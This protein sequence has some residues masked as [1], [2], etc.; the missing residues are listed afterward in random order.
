MNSSN[1]VEIL[2]RLDKSEIR[3]FNRWLQSPFYNK[4]EDVLSLFLYLIKANHLSD[5]RY[6]QKTRV[7]SK[8]FPKEQYDD[9]KLRQ[10]VHFLNKQV[11]AFLSHLQLEQ[12]PHTKDLAFLK[13]LRK[14]KLK[15]AFQKKMN[16]LQKTQLSN[17]ALDSKGLRS[18]FILNDENYSFFLEANQA[19]EDHLR[20]TVDL[21]DVQFVAEKLK[22]ACLELSHNK[23]FKTNYQS[24]FLDVVLEAVQN[25]PTLLEYPAIKVYYY[26]YLMQTSPDKAAS[27]YSQLKEAMD[28]F[29]FST[30]EKKDIYLMVLNYCVSRMNQ[31]DQFFLRE[32]FGLF[33]R[34]ITTG[35][36]IQNGKLSTIAYLNTVSIGLRLK[37]FDEIA[38][39]IKDFT[40]FLPEADRT[41]TQQYSLAK[42][43]FEQ[44]QYG[45]VLDLLATFDT[46]HI[47]INLNAKS[48]ML[49]VFYELDELDALESYLE[50]FRAY[51]NRKE[52]ISY[53]RPIYSNLVKFT[54]KLVRVNAYDSTQLEKLRQEIETANPLP[55]RP[56]LLEQLAKLV[57]G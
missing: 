45:E 17:T 55:E 30:E 14:K 49:K 24:K 51:L 25:D 26:S 42:L 22:Y 41:S 10:T 53:H 23:V 52:I 46:K 50:S 18:A 12:E 44:K 9:A 32:A 1:L 54:R 15:K 57:S 19:K 28:D 2:S 56:W 16:A 11:E 39:F 20:K 5:E 36:L 43:Y 40:Q 37:E 33:M 21:F 38:K 6:L 29:A 13:I 3:S 8:L 34:G 48:M 47:L 27:H 35:V 4:R 7:F 31:G